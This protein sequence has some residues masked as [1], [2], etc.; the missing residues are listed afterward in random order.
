MNKIIIPQNFNY[1]AAFITFDCS[2]KCNY[3]INRFGNFK[4]RKAMNGANWVKGLSRIETREDLPISIQGGE[5]C[6]HPDF[7]YIAKELHKQKKQLDLLTNGTFDVRKFYQNIP[8]CIFKRQAKY[9]S[10]RFSYHQNSNILGL[11]MKIQSLRLRGYSVGVW[12]LNHPLMEK[13]NAEME[14]LCKW[15][16]IDYREK[17]FLDETYK[18]YKYPNAISGKRSRNLVMCRPSELLIAPDGNIFKCHSNLYSGFNP[19]ANILD[20]NVV[21]ENKFYSCGNYGLCNPCDVKI[22]TNRFQEDGHTSMEIR[23]PDNK[24]PNIGNCKGY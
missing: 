1:I 3:C 20:E 21:I 6:D 8:S 18:R 4:Y 16:G 10:I 7:Y 5:P 9:A 15:L 17:G 2:L 11:V 23:F 13:K 24:N 12:S 14:D 22:K 19:I